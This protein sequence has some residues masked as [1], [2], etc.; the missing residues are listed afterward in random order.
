MI[1]PYYAY[2]WSSVLPRGIGRLPEE[3]GVDCEGKNRD[4]GRPGENIVTIIFFS[5]FFFLFNFVLL[6][7][8]VFSYFFFSISFWFAFVFHLIFNMFCLFLSCYLLLFCVFVLFHFLH[9][10]AFV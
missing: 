7:V 1:C 5:S 8:F 6:F 3:A 2:S 9:Y 10:Y 4:S